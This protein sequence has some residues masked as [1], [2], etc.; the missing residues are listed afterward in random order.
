[1]RYL[2]IALVLIPLFGTA[3]YAKLY[4]R[5]AS[6]LIPDKIQSH[7]D[8]L[9]FGQRFVY[10]YSQLDAI[11]F[12]QKPDTSFVSIL[13]ANNVKSVDRYSDNSYGS[14]LEKMKEFLNVDYVDE[15]RKTQEFGKKLQA[16]G[17]VLVASSVVYPSI[18]DNQKTSRDFKN[19]KNTVTFLGIT[20]AV[21]FTVGIVFDIGAERH[22][23]IWLRK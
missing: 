21:S 11:L 13:E 7:S 8:Q 23:L 22:K 18:F 20:G 9:I 2:L 19:L 12:Y 3:Q 10:S 1:M 5:N 16:L 6:E 14:E 4:K 17:V 15:Y